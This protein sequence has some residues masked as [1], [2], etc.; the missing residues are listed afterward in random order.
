VTPDARTIVSGDEGG[1]VRLWPV[2]PLVL[3]KSAPTSP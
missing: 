2:E 3:S 1:M